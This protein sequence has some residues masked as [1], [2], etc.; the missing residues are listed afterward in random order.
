MASHG[1]LMPDDLLQDALPS[2]AK[3]SPTDNGIGALLSNRGV[4]TLGKLLPTLWRDV[5]CPILLHVAKG[6]GVC[7]DGISATGEL[8]VLLH[9][10]MIRA[11]VR[12]GSRRA[13]LVK[14]YPLL[15]H[16]LKGLAILCTGCSLDA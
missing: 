6:L 1:H 10:V 16:P 2:R 14:G 3:V 4:D 15:M 13:S 7:R 9:H 5:R 11:V 12:Q 8:I